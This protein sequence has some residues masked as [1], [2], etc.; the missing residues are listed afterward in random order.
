M[1]PIAPSS[2]SGPSAAI[3]ASRIRSRTSSTS[4]GTSHESPWLST[5]IG[6][7]STAVC[8]PN[9]S[10]GVVDEHR[11]D[12]SRTSPSRSGTWPPPGPL[13]VVGVDRAP[14]DR[15]DVSSSSAD[16]CSPSVWRLTER[17]RASA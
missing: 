4:P 15:R 17:S 12:G 11:I 3:R 9:G 6:R 10:V 5:V 1:I 8:T 14:G 7:C 16:S 13:H 2:W